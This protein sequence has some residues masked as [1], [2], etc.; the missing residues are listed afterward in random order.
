MQ[1]KFGKF[2]KLSLFA[3]YFVG[4]FSYISGDKINIAYL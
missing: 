2:S 1:I 3:S 4:I